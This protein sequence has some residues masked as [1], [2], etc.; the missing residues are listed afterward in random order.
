MHEPLADS[1]KCLD[2]SITQLSNPCEWSWGWCF[3]GDKMK[4]R[5][6]VQVRLSTYCA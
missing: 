5:S 4:P 3:W 2:F 6:Y 1:A